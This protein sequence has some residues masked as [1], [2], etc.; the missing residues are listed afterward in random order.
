MVLI[1]VSIEKYV[2]PTGAVPLPS[3]LTSY[4]PIKCNLYLNN[5]FET[6]IR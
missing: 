5:F 2:S 3:H 4:T 6:V 1:P